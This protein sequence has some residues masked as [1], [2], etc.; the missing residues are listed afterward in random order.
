MLAAAA[1][2]VACDR[3]AAATARTTDSS[4][5]A[6]PNGGVIDSILPMAEYFRRFRAGL[7]TVDGFAGGASSQETL[8]RR[9]LTAIAAR[10]TTAV[11]TLML[12]R[13]EF[14]WLYYPDHELAKA[15]YEIAP[16]Y[17]WGQMQDG[18]VKGITRA[19]ERLGGK[20]LVFRS[21]SCDPVAKKVVG[22]TTEYARCVVTVD[23]TGLS[24][25]DV[26]LFSAI[27]ERDGRFKFLSYANDL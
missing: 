16:S 22:A 27:V 12:S 25:Q 6:A 23:G 10:D 14:A 24:R 8:V 26:R 13:A 21:L 2:S 20:P 9:L 19:F 7:D 4:A 1:C 15:P 17:I 18:S 3:T 11:R 5:V